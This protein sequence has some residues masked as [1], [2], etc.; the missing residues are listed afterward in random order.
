MGKSVT[1]DQ[2]HEVMA[3]LATNVDWDTLD[4][5]VLQEQ[6]VRKPMEA[7]KQFTA[8]LKNG[9]RVIV[10][11][12]KVIEIYRSESFNPAKFI[13]EGWTIEEQDE[14][15]LALSELDLTK[16]QFKTMLK[17]DEPYVKG[18]E[19]LR[20]LKETGYIRLDAKIFQTLWEN[21]ALI[22]EDWK[23]KINNNTRYVF[24]DGTILRAPRGHRC[25]LSLYWGAGRWHW[26]YHW[27]G[28]DWYL[29]SPSALLA[30]S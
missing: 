3:I 27:L 18:E 4:G 9:G 23:E 2:S 15:S 28:D 8:F 21:Q 11:E 20:R 10:G 14:R 19:K 29:S 1:I 26:G 22:P 6:I 16:I 12:P 7:G 17:D 25:V 24:F 30:S 13:G 5:S